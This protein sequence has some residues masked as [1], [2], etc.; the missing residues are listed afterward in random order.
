MALFG[1][2]I[3]CCSEEAKT[4]NKTP[5]I[6]EHVN[7]AR[8]LQCVESIFGSWRAVSPHTRENCPS[9]WNGQATGRVGVLAT[10]HLF[11]CPGVYLL[12]QFSNGSSVDETQQRKYATGSSE[13]R[14]TVSEVLLYNNTEYDS[15]KHN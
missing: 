6:I 5:S 10:H 13:T 1:I 2:P 12:M 8:A 3:S 14:V 7:K 4:T 9:D 15:N 11:I